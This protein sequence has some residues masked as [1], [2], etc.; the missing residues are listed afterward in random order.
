MYA[1]TAA[2][3]NFSGLVRHSYLR[4]GPEQG[5]LQITLTPKH[6]RDRPS[7]AV[8]LDIRKRLEGV[9]IPHGATLKVMEVP[10]GPPVLSTLLAEI[11]GPDAKTRRVMA[12]KVKEA[13]DRVDS[14]VDV[15]DTLGD[16]SQRLRFV[17]V[18]E[19][20]EFHGVQEA[21]VHETLQSLLGGV[22]VGYSHRGH[23]H[24]PHRNRGPS[25]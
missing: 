6:T 21:H 12:E 17:I 4:K 8:A 9:S 2:P 13:F 1:G 3:F 22:R 20:L 14:I 15:D 19:Q 25:A 18:P 23:G 7:H 11:Y 5:E 24:H 16:S 10:P